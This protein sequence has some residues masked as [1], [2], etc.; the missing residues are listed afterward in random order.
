MLLRASSTCCPERCAGD[1]DPFPGILVS[2]GD[3]GES[4]FPLLSVSPGDKLL[5]A[6]IKCCNSTSAV[7]WWQTL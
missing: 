6:F 5:T 4:C 7:G 2:L 3:L 1:V